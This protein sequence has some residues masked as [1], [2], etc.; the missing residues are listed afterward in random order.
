LDKRISIII[1]TKDAEDTIEA[2]LDSILENNYFHEIII[3]DNSTDRTRQILSK[4]PVKVIDG[5]CMNVSEKSNLGIN[6]ASGEIIGFTDQDCVVPKDWVLRAKKL[7]KE[8][9]SN[10]VGG[11]NL[12]MSDSDFGEKCSGAIL[13]SW[14]GSG[15]SIDRYKMRNQSKSLETDELKITSCN[16]FLEKAALE[17]IGGFNP[18]LYSCEENDLL[19]RMKKKGFKVLYDPSLYIWHR[20]RPIFRPFFKQIFWYGNGRGNFLRKTPS[21]LRMVHIIPPIFALG[22]IF[23]FIMSLFN[24]LREPYMLGLGLYFTIDILSSAKIASRRK[25][26]VKAIPVLLVT[27]FL[28][29][30]LYGVGLLYGLFARIYQYQRD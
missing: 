21:S 13:E 2:C 10:V 25:F 29:H 30:F 22:I 8:T 9:K 14:F 28:T 5:K 1:P 15:Q 26:G 18:G 19:F 20:R 27:F 23:G 24:L 4:Y 6:K 17:E 11:P 16:F 3:V 7:M 12:T